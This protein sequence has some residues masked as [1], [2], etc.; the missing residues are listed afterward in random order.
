MNYFLNELQSP[1]HLIPLS[2]ILLF[3]F[4]FFNGGLDARK[5]SDI[6]LDKLKNKA[7]KGID[8]DLHCYK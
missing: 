2:R 5:G 6:D 8:H 7:F 1:F 4:M 3:N